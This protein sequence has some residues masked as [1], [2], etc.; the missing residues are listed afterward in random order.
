MTVRQISSVVGGHFQTLLSQQEAK[1]QEQLSL[2]RQQ[3]QTQQVKA[4]ML[5]RLSVEK[6]SKERP[7]RSG[8]TS[9]DKLPSRGET[10]APV[11][12]STV[13]VGLGAS[14]QPLSLELSKWSSKAKPSRKD[15]IL[16]EIGREFSAITKEPSK[17]RVAPK[18]AGPNLTRLSMD[19]KNKGPP[20]PAT[21]S[22]QL[23]TDEMV[24]PIQSSR[25]VTHDANV[26]KQELEDTSNVKVPDSPDLFATRS[27][28]RI[29]LRDF[30]ENFSNANSASPSQHVLESSSKVK[31]LTE[32]DESRA[33]DG[34]PARNMVTPP[35]PP[36]PP[37]T[38]Q[39]P[40]ATKVDAA[41]DT[42]PDSSKPKPQTSPQREKGDMKPTEATSSQEPGPD[43]SKAKLRTSL[44]LEH[45]EEGDKE[46]KIDG[47]SDGTVLIQT[48]MSEKETAI[49]GKGGHA[50]LL[51][52]SQLGS[53]EQEE[54]ELS[55][56]R[57]KPAGPHG[58]AGK[59]P[60]AAAAT[61]ERGGGAGSVVPKPAAQRPAPAPTK[62]ERQPW[63]GKF[64]MSVSLLL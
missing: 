43:L 21:Y 24:P 54:A 50:L 16:E 58:G 8:K 47:D 37:L 64:C 42:K 46:T 4:K 51:P 7:P 10:P 3:Q 23:S 32:E 2:Q 15:A 48:I 28:T 1:L 12:S 31:T 35:P 20:G 61:A 49:V 18:K 45:K 27:R 60:A 55:R 9:P 59:P 14:P 26:V 34:T 63:P 13:D 56:A 29:S 30:E 38:S 17:R 62:P 25:I 22:T 33:T 40:T 44:I 41:K 36:P 52:A 57:M 6:T 53:F 39:A 11:D 19:H 5:K